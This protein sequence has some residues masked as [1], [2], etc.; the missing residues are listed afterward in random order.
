MA[1][2]PSDLEALIPGRAT[3]RKLLPDPV[4][5]E[6]LKAAIAAAGWAPSPHG[7]QPWRFVVIEST[8]VKTRLATAMAV[9]WQAQLELDGQNEA[10]VSI[11]LAKS[12]ER[13]TTAPAIIIACLYLDDLDTYPDPIRQQAEHTMAVQSLGAAIQSALLTIYAAGYDAGWMCA[14][15]FAPDVVRSA[16]D[17]SPSLIP[18]AMIPV[19]KR[20]ADSVR[21]PRLPTDE[22]IAA[23]L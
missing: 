19:G 8:E 23:W 14:P 16:L 7:R 22:L 4:P 10:I 1:D 12:Q 2:R 11:R 3:V 6:T 17:L 9:T 18:H 5:P 21:R 20:A 15:L 13:I